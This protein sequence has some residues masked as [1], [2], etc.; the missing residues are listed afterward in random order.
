MRIFGS[1]AW[2]IVHDTVRPEATGVAYMTTCRA[3]GEPETREFASI[4]AAR[5]NLEAFAEAAAG[6][7]PYP[8]P[9]AEMVHNIA[10]LEA[11]T[12]SVA[13]GAATRVG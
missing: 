5:V 3:G 1:D 8:I 13:S 10:V 9:R 7:A 11:I 2:V 4:D 6:G 12:A